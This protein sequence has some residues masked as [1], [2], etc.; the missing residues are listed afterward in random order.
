MEFAIYGRCACV[1]LASADA[2]RVITFGDD[3]ISILGNHSEIAILQLEVKPP[4]CARVKM[5]ALES[6]RSDLGRT[7]RNRESEIDLNDLITHYLASV[8]HRDVSLNW[9][10]RS[11]SI[12][13]QTK[14]PVGEACV[15]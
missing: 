7:F 5:N 12:C 4:A 1:E 8:G 6:T 11:Y 9:L 2:D 14:V 13:G 3:W 15:A 10:S